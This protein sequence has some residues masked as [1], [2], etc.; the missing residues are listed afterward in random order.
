MTYPNRCFN[1]AAELEVI[2][3]LQQVMLTAPAEAAVR[4]PRFDYWR[5]QLPGR[6]TC[7][8]VPFSRLRLHHACTARVSALVSGCLPMALAAVAVVQA[9]HTK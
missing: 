5:P 8:R 6:G 9:R 2:F 7:A 4:H 3:E 1:L